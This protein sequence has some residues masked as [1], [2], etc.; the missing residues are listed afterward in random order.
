MILKFGIDQILASTFPCV[1]PP[2]PT[3][4][5]PAT[6]PSSISPTFA[7]PNSVNNMFPAWVF[8]T[9]YSD[10]P[11]AG[12]RHR[13]PR[14]RESTGSSGSSEEEK[15]PRTAFTS[16]QLDRL[17]QEFRD[18]RYL[19]EKRRQELAHELGLNES[20]I[21]IWFQNKRAKL[22]KTTGDHHHRSAPT[23]NNQFQIMAQL[24]QSQTHHFRQ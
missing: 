14:K 24:A 6:S 23:P 9:R 13:K 19:T 15:R 11:S 2:S 10:R 16:E 4:S 5:T 18:N 17:K 12:P 20:Q 1:S 21:K 8:C 22:K 7:S 3:I